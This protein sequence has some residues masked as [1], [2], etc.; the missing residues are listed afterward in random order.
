MKSR[1]THHRFLT[2]STL[3]VL[4]CMLVMLPCFWNQTLTASGVMLSPRPAFKLAPKTV[5]IG[6]REK[7]GLDWSRDESQPLGLV[8][9]STIEPLLIADLAVRAGVTANFEIADIAFDGSRYLVVWSEYVNSP[10][11]TSFIRGQFITAAGALDGAMFT[12]G[13]NTSSGQFRPAVAFNGTNYL[14]VWE[15]Q[16]Q[17][18]GQMVTPIGTLVGAQI[19]IANQGVPSYP[20][21]AS[22]GNNF[23]VVWTDQRS[24]ATNLF[25]IFGQLVTGSGGLSGGNILVSPGPGGSEQF[26][27]VTFGGGVY[28]VAWRREPILNDFANQDIYGARVTP[29]G[30]ILDPASIGIGTAP[31][32]QGSYLAAGVAFDGNN[33]LVVWDDGRQGTGAVDIYGARVS[34]ATGQVLDP[35]GIAISTNPGFGA[36]HGPKV[37]FDG[38]NW[39]VVWAGTLTRGARVNSAGAVLDSSGPALYQ[40]AT[41]QWAP[42]VASD[43]SKF[44]VTWRRQTGIGYDV[45]TQLVDAPSNQPPL[46]QCQNVTVSAN[47][48]CEASASIDNGSSDPDGDAITLTQSPPGLYP[49]GTTTVTLTATDSSG[50]S[51]SCTATVTVVDAA[52]PQ[53]VPPPNSSYQCLSQ[54][55]PG[56]ASQATATDNCGAPT[57]TV[58]DAS[59]GGAGSPSSPLVITRYFT[60]TDAAGNSASASQ[61][62]TVIDNTPPAVTAPPAVNVSTGSGATAC[63]VVVSNAALGSAMASDNCGTA[64]VT[65]SGVPVGNLFPV[66]MT[67]IT[68]TATDAAGNTATATQTVSVA[69]N[70]NPTITAPPNITVNTG[71]TSCAATGVS[72]GTPATAD[73]CGVASVTNNAPSS[74]SIGST[75]VTWTV[76][77]VNG[78]SATATQVVSVVNN[79][80]T[81]VSAGGVYNV[82]EGGSVTVTASGSDPEG[83]AVSFAW[84]LDN[85]GSFETAGQSA[86]FSAATI[87]GPASR[88]I[89]VRVADNCGLA[90]IAQTT[91]NVQ[92][93]APAVG[94]ISASLDPVQVNT[95]VNTSA[96]FTDPGVADAHTAEWDWGDGSASLGSVTE[97][98]G[99]G[100][101]GGSHTYA[102][103]G[104]YVVTLTVTDDDNGSG[105]SIFQYIVVYDPNSGFVTGGGWINSPAG[106]YTPDPSLTGKANFGFVSKYQNGASVPTGNTEFQFKAG[107]LNF[108]STAYEW[109]V[110]AGKKA[111]Y[112]GSGKI[113]GAG[114]Y[115]FMLTVIDGQQPG[116]GGQDKFRIRIWN[117]QGGGLVYDNQMSMPDNDDPTTVLGGGSIVIHKP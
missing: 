68:Y 89:R 17:A 6:S 31:N 97:S 7:T 65:Q 108:K 28:L 13:A 51:S 73:N 42:T 63:G 103:P 50:A 58:A 5:S 59:N 4:T 52:Q 10:S 54:V 2:S 83:G 62:I 74:F 41:T 60:A 33:F 35:A 96:G 91:V 90:T 117:N 64:N 99:S 47:S 81:G 32:S 77:D 110:V 45:Y 112:K 70:T 53:V 94:T 3:V 98:G 44:L 23:L 22:D 49:L 8:T 56:N 29:L 115:R 16:S 102:A 116:G 106:A 107:N 9:T 61:T 109:L 67:T 26:P 95:T 85:N 76:T 57:I 92:N 14:V 100:S 101:T 82:D 36:P 105:Q 87:D 48:T 75:T 21:V 80:P 38:T 27:S 93:V 30:S 88:I 18:Q 25:D 78:N 66:G 72:L 104:V 19:V 113:N 15:G 11:F 114:D 20:D 39:L 86:M 40:T 43:G 55:P 84:D 71:A 37:A 1:K 12:I 24:F 111:Q 79:A 34:A 46:A 69:D